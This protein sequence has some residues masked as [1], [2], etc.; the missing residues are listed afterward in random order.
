MPQ[1]C[2][3][4]HGGGATRNG[5]GGSFRVPPTSLSHQAQFLIV[6]H[7]VRPELAAIIAALAFGGS[8]THG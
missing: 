5:C 3:T 1:K 4:P 6:A 7:H 2:E 8:G